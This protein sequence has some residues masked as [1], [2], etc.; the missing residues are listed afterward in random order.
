MEDQES[1]SR[2]YRQSK[3]YSD[4]LRRTLGLRNRNN[5]GAGNIDEACM[6]LDRLVR[7]RRGYSGCGRQSSCLSDVDLT[8]F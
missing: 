5:A 3:T 6:S 2:H 8:D 1:T 7:G 4:C